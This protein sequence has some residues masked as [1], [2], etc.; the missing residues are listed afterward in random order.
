MGWEQAQRSMNPKVCASTRATD[1]CMCATGTGPAPARPCPCHAL[2]V[3]VWWCDGGVC[4]GN[5]RIRKISPNGEVTTLCGGGC[6]TATTSAASASASASSSAASAGSSGSS[7]AAAA[8]VA[9]AV[10][11]GAHR[12][13]PLHTALFHSPHAIVIALPPLP[14]HTASRRRR[15]KRTAHA[16]KEEGAED[17]DDKEQEQEEEEEPS[18]AES[19]AEDAEDAEEAEAERRDSTVLY[20]SDRGSHTVRRIEVWADGSGGAVSTVAGRAGASGCVDGAGTSSAR[21]DAPS[22]CAALALCMAVCDR[23]RSDHVL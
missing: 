7:S 6:S 19:D 11:G 3:M 18:G 21:L 4:S 15:H 14:L 16:E 23:R 10:V 1:V 17:D 12:D 5:H 8:A 2:C 9:V 20:V 13:G 22:M